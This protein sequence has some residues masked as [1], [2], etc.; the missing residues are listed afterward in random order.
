MPSAHCLSDNVVANISNYIRITCKFREKFGVAGGE[1]NDLRD[2]KVFKDINVIKDPKDFKDLTLPL[3][4]ENYVFG[5]EVLLLPIRK[6]FI[7][8]KIECINC[9]IYGFW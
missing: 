7:T 4:A 6:F 1:P 9:E 3:P 8:L 5:G 2:F